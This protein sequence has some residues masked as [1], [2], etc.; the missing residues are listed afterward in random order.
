MVR[1]CLTVTGLN[2]NLLILLLDCSILI[3]VGLIPGLNRNQSDVL[4]LF[5]VRKSL[6]WDFCLICIKEVT[7]W[8]LQHGLIDIEMKVHHSSSS[9][10][11]AAFWERP[12]YL[13]LISE[14]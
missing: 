6:Q 2:K 3:N 9:F 7:W 11:E 1:P 12:G 4:L 14:G 10:P 13:T 5:S 8:Y